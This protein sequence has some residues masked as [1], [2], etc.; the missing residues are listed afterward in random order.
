METVYLVQLAVTAATLVHTWVDFLSA[1]TLARGSTPADLP[2]QGEHLAVLIPARDEELNI[3]ECL[4]SLTAQDLPNLDIVVIDDGSTDKTAEIVSNVAAR[5]PRVRLLS[6]P[7]RPAEWQGKSWAL[8][9]GVL[10]TSALWIAM[11]DADVRLGPHA[12]RRAWALAVERRVAL[13]SL[14]PALLD[15]TFWEKVIQPVVGFFLFVGQPL[16]LVRSPRSPVVVANGQFLL[17]NRNEYTRAGGHAAVKKEI[18]EDVELAR[19]MKKQGMPVLL[20]P[21]FFDLRVRMY[22]GF[23]G[24]WKGWGKTIHPYIAQAP[25]GVWVGISVLFAI[26]VGP[27]LTLPYLIVTNPHANA[28]R[29]QLAAC[30][31]ILTSAFAFRRM[32]RH[33]L[34]HGLFWPL[35]CLV[36][37]ALFVARTIGVVLGKGVDWKGRLYGQSAGRAVE[38]HQPLRV[39][40]S[41][42]PFVESQSAEGASTAVPSVRSTPLTVAKATFYGAR[43]GLVVLGLAAI[44]C[45]P[46]RWVLSGFAEPGAL[47]RASALLLGLAHDLTVLTLPCAVLAAVLSFTHFPSRRVKRALL[48]LL[49]VALWIFV[50]ST[51]E[52]SLSRGIF[53]TW[54]DVHIMNNS[55]DMMRDSL[56]MFT[57][58]RNVLPTLAV[59]PFAALILATWPRDRAANAVMSSPRRP[60]RFA[61]FWGGMGVGLVAGA[62]A[63]ASVWS[64]VQT[65]NAGPIGTPLALVSPTMFAEAYTCARTSCEPSVQLEHVSAS[66]ETVARGAALLGWPAP[67]QRH[68]PILN[69]P[70]S[71]PFA[72]SFPSVEVVSQAAPKT[73]AARELLVHLDRLSHELFAEDPRPI[74]VFQV[75]ME[76]MRGDDLSSINPAAPPQLSP[77]LASLYNQANALTPGVLASR[78][79]WTAGVRTPHGLAALQCGLGTLPF[80]LALPR[81]LPN[82]PMRCLPDVLS[83]AGFSVG[84]A[85]GGSLSF[86]RIGAFF[87]AHHST[88]W[89]TAGT[90]PT[91]TPQ[92]AWGATDRSVYTALAGATPSQ[93]STYALVLTLSHHHPFT[94][95]GDLPME[96]RARVDEAFA[97][98]NPRAD[99]DDLNRLITFAY[100]DDALEHFF[101]TLAE[102][103]LLDRTIVSIAADHAIPDKPLWQHLPNALKTPASRA[104]IPALIWISPKLLTAGSNPHKAQHLAVQVQTI[105]ADLPLSQN[106]LPTL[107]LALLAHHPALRA[108]ES[109]GLHWHSM[110]GQTTSIWYNAPGPTTTRI[111]AIHAGTAL[112]LVDGTYPTA[113]DEPSPFMLTLEKGRAVTPSLEPAAATLR[114]LLNA[115]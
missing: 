94:L 69:S 16:W 56:G 20:A 100:A 79:T 104:L 42:A 39:E 41:N 31:L 78:H 43:C 62:L 65:R 9:N 49:T 97:R 1:P 11:I 37:F 110:G 106:D 28:T 105:L 35:A 81:D 45:V 4:A 21:A 32:T 96:V 89:V 12:L 93:T 60:V 108:L 76:G 47:A 87:S 61:A 67:S 26:F 5:D 58:Q 54:V 14:L 57:L 6:C 99:A 23:A 7:P 103:G 114:F 2:I 109:R 71:H 64:G 98:A 15:L 77:F 83:D 91:D 19:T 24:I 27:F 70:P 86:D 13:L 55:P 48:A 75:A 34:L 36:F 72:R 29:A 33:E 112:T 18:V 59:L 111:H 73:F 10:A 30:L 8:H 22:Q 80:G 92:G 44:A 102:R 25:I 84:H 101:S 40:P 66:P 52:S 38:K 46:S 50:V 3:G 85:Y 113:P 53:P 82:L 115:D 107:L 63:Q 74:H 68:L 51:T 90:L 17:V 88:P 95:P